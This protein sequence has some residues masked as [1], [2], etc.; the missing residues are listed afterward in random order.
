MLH[1]LH[2]VSGES[3]CVT[4]TPRKRAKRAQVREIAPCALHCAKIYPRNNELASHALEM[5]F[6]RN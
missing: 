1:V 6:W 2:G 3:V 4:Y 5:V